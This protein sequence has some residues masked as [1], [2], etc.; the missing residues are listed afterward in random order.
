M[1]RMLDRQN[2]PEQYKHWVM[3]IVRGCPRMQRQLSDCAQ[4]GS[5]PV[6]NPAKKT[7]WNTAN[8]VVGHS[9]NLQDAAHAHTY[10]ITQDVC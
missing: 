5:D 3:N 7:K 2:R 8:L 6:S 9:P 1:N 4:A 10:I